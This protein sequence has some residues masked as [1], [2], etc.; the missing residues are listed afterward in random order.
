M[1]VSLRAAAGVL[2]LAAALV[3]PAGP[4]AADHVADLIGPDQSICRLGGLASGIGVDLVT[5]DVK[6]RIMRDGLTVTYVCRFAEVPAYV[7]A[8][9]S[10][11]GQEWVRPSQASRGSVSC[12]RPEFESRDEGIGTFVITPNGSATLTCKFDQH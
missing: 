11:T 10:A 4:A 7:S 3:G 2:V 8:E 12:W 6:A 9:E 5:T 1:L